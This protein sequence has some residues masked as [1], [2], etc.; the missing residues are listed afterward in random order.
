MTEE[1]PSKL[2]TFFSLLPLIII[3]GTCIVAVIFA[4]VF[5]PQFITWLKEPSPARVVTDNQT[6]T[7]SGVLSTLTYQYGYWGSVDSTKISFL[8]GR[9]FQFGSQ[10]FCELGKKFTVT[11]NEITYKDE[12]TET[13]MVSIIQDSS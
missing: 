8:D 1:K 2:D 4:F 10:V 3:V 5:G 12:H 6:L 13:Q 9:E 7:Y 11:W